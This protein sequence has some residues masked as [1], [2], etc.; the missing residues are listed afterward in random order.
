MESLPKTIVIVGPTAGGKTDLSLELAARLPGGGECV[1]ADS[2]QVYCGMD[3]GTAKPTAEEQARVPHHLLDL[4]EPSED[5]FSVDTWLQLARQII[6]DIAARGSV[7]IVVGGT[8]LYIQALL[9]GMFEGPVPNDDLR[10]RLQSMETEELRARLEEVDPDAAQRLHPN[11]RKRTVRA[12]E[13]FELTGQPI[14]ALQDQWSAS[15]PRD[16]IFVVGLGFP[17]EVINKRINARVK[18]MMQRGLRDEVHSLW[19]N[20]QLGRQASEALGYKQMI[21]AFEARTTEEEA[22][23]QIKIQT[24]RYARKQRTWLKRFRMHQPGLWLDAADQS[25]QELCNKA[26]ICI[27]AWLDACG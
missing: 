22:F 21:D 19:A 13:V 5:G 14:S 12:I 6:G 26:L 8:N 2:M 11:D 9:Y 18:L 17:P 24:R 25:A 15:R 1:C 10:A 23:E 20:G 27:E 16:D 7:P 4:L 3:I